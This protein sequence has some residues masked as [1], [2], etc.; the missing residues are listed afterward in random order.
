VVGI[1]RLN[2]Q[3]LTA[4][5]IKLRVRSILPYARQEDLSCEIALDRNELVDPGGL[6]RLDGGF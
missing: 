3:N 5:R 4:A 2:S 6:P 1:P